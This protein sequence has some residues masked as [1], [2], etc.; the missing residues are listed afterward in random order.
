MYGMGENLNKCEVYSDICQR[1][2]KCQGL[3]ALEK[4]YK[5]NPNLDPRA[6]MTR[7]EAEGVVENY[8]KMSCQCVA[9][10]R[11]LAEKFPEL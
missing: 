7:T 4:D 8:R 2:G 9:K 3:L 1:L 5:L 10:M 11:R 6:K